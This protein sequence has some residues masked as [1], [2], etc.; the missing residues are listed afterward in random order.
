M[1]AFCP[2]CAI[3]NRCESEPSKEKKISENEQ[4]Y[5]QD[6]AQNSKGRDFA[7][8]LELWALAA[9]ARRSRAALHSQLYRQILRV[10]RSELPPRLRRLGDEYVRNEWKQVR[11]RART[12]PLVA[13]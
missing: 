6:D 8:V 10:H 1:E 13:C 9:T 3:V 2:I 11:L 12:A 5:C 7:G 4:K